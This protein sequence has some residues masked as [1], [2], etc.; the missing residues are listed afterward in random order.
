MFDFKLPL[1]KH[2][3]P[4]RC[5]FLGRGQKLGNKL[6]TRIRVG[7]SYLNEHSYQI[8]MA[9]SPKCACLYSC[10]S[11]LHYFLDCPIFLLPSLDMTLEVEGNFSHFQEEN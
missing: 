1:K 3:A 11:P 8:Q 9:P 4:L 5:K 10:E 6:L 2:L 7:R